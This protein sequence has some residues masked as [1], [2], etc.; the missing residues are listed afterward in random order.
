VNPRRIRRK[1]AVVSTRI[2][3]R[4]APTRKAIRW[5]LHALSEVDI[6][7]GGIA[8]ILKIVGIVLFAPAVLL[9]LLVFHLG[10]WEKK[11]N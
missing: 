6:S 3:R 2:G 5:S 7:I 9:V 4:L 11:G 10:G 8:Q 1:A